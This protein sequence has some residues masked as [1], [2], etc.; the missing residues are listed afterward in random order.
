MQTVEKTRTVKVPISVSFDSTLV[1]QIDSI[2]KERGC[3]RSWFVNK[4]VEE[5]ML[6]YV[7]DRDDYETAVAAL[8]EFEKGDGKTYT[9]EEVYEEAGL[10]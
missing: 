1:E 9:L 10:L 8:E 3:T 7:E 6:E 2:C 5:Y 4:A